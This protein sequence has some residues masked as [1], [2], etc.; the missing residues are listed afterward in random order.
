V[1]ASCSSH[2]HAL[3]IVAAVPSTHI[4]PSARLTSCLVRCLQPVT[5]VLHLEYAQRLGALSDGQLLLL[6]ADTM[7]G[8]PLPGIKVKQPC[9]WG[10]NH[11]QPCTCSPIQCT[12]VPGHRGMCVCRMHEAAAPQGISAVAA[13]G[14]GR[15]GPTRLAVAARPSRRA[16]RVMVFQLTGGAA[17][18]MTARLLGQADVPSALPI[19]VSLCQSQSRHVFVCTR[20]SLSAVS[21]VLELPCCSGHAVV[22][23]LATSY[24]S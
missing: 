7:E 14:G 19:Q 22:E 13:D 17:G 10:L 18:S 6:D 15:G 2:G 5:R 4:H 11:A 1:Q 21:T 3:A 23:C 8:Q 9:P 20:C 12:V 24:M 16:T